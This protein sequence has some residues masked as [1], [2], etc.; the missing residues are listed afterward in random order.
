M[1]TNVSLISIIFLG[2]II[3]SPPSQAV[4]IR[5]ATQ[6]F[7]NALTVKGEP[8]IHCVMAELNQTFKISYMPWRRAQSKTEQGDFDGFFMASQNKVRDVYATL[9]SPFFQLNGYI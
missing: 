5:L 4:D 8:F 6:P 3:A 2:A 9:S 7:G 1:S